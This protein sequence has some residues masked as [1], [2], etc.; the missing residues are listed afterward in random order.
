M[1]FQRPRQYF[2]GSRIRNLGNPILMDKKI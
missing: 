2:N 1:I